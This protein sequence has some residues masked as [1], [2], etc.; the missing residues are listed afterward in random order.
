LRGTL[1]LVLAALVAS[2]GAVSAAPG[3]ELASIASCDRLPGLDVAPFL[4]SELRPDGAPVVASPS[5]DGATVPVVFVHG[6]AGS[7]SHN[8]SRDGAFSKFIDLSALA[9][10][11]DPVPRSL[12]GQIQDL[13][14]TVVLTFDYKGVNQ[15]WVTDV[16]IGDS[17][18]TA[19]DCLY[20]ATGEK[21]IILGHS[22]GG[23][24]ARHALSGDS[25]SGVSRAEE[26]SDVITFG[27]PNLGSFLG[28]VG[29]AGMDF[30]SSASS[31]VKAI[32]IAALSQCRA[33][34]PNWTSA[35][36]S[37]VCGSY[38][39]VLTADREATTRGDA[40][41]AL[42]WRSPEL[43]DLASWP[44]A[45]DIHALAGQTRVSVPSYGWFGIPL[46]SPPVSVGDWIVPESSALD[47]ADETRTLTCD[48]QLAFG[49]STSDTLQLL[50][51]VKAAS[52]VKPTVFERAAWACSHGNLMRTFEL[53]NEA[54]G[55]VADE[56]EQRGISASDPFAGT[57]A[58]DIVQDGSQAYGVEL[59]LDESNGSYTGVVAYEDLGCSGRLLNG[60]AAEE[61]L[62]IHERIDVNG[63]C[64]VDVDLTL[65][66]L[67]NDTLRYAFD[68]DGATG[69]GILSRRGDPV[70]LWDVPSLATGGSSGD[71]VQLEWEGPGG[72]LASSVGAEQWVG[73]AS[74][75]TTTYDIGAEYTTLDWSFVLADFAPIGLDVSLRL[76]LDGAV[77]VD[78]RVRPGAPL[79]D[80]SIEVT[81]IEHLSVEAT[82][83][84]QCSGSPQG[85]GAFINTGLIR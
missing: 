59:T 5:A 45:V 47:D 23:L 16:R 76:L 48:A 39:P 18:A 43:Q 53:T 37:S 83:F 17:L 33:L 12:I 6:W 69:E 32:T 34:P 29:R 38:E 51:Q 60:T 31:N 72:V 63:T 36:R 21:A 79:L 30:A 52:E 44:A 7:D 84:S 77:A 73:C 8:D 81:G 61:V 50:I 25:P 85:Y 74:T 71:L 15:Q 66:H 22:M 14:G 64:V 9:L 46:D 49:R 62:S 42:A 11:P 24:A 68:H 10:T 65:T 54:L 4:A 35:A 2:T 26:V 28:S 57:W 70:R 1:K 55:I 56:L 75:A 3:A 82:T 41:S 13:P 40:L 67:E 58:G 27:T 20:S 19:M 78:E 80:R